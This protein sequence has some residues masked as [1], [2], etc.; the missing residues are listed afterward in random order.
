MSTLPGDIIFVVAVGQTDRGKTAE[1][2]EVRDYC[3]AHATG[4]SN[5]QIINK[6]TDRDRE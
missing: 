6:I 1:A 5:I 2:F 3:D 4:G